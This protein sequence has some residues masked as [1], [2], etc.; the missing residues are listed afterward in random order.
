M[1]IKKVTKTIVITLLPSKINENYDIN[2]ITNLNGDTC[3]LPVQ[4][5]DQPTKHYYVLFVDLLFVQRTISMN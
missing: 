5:N 2:Y 4:M 3:Y 1:N